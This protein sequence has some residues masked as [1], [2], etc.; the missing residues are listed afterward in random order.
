MDER[1]LSATPERRF[2]RWIAR[3]RG[4]I[5]LSVSVVGF[6]AT[7]TATALELLP[8]DYGL[9]LLRALFEG[10][11]VGSIADWFAVTALFKKIP[12]PFLSRHTNLLARR[13]AAM[14]DGI[15]DM[16]QTQWLS[17][18]AV[19]EYLSRISCSQMLAER[20][21]CEQGRNQLR[22]WTRRGLHIVINHLDH[23]T[24]VVLLEHVLQ[25][26]LRRWPAPEQITP[27]VLRLMRDRTLE[28]QIYTKLARLAV[29]LQEDAALLQS[30]QHM[31]L[32]HIEA[33]AAESRWMRTKLWLGKQFIE[34]EDDAEK[35]GHLLTQGLSA[36]SG[37]LD[38][39]AKQ[40]HHPMRLALRRQVLLAARRYD[41]SDDPHED[42][43]ERLKTLFL[44]IWVQ[45]DTAEH[46]L[47]H[48]KV[49]LQK[50]VQ[51][52]TRGLLATLD[53]FIYQQVSALLTTSPYRIQL[54]TYINNQLSDMVD[55]NPKFFGDIVRESLSTTKLPTQQLIDQVENKVGQ[56]L[57][58]IRVNG[59]LVGGLV[60]V[61]IAAL[62]IAL[63]A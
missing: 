37:Q 30:I 25:R 40:V 55:R 28:T 45:K 18:Q 15:V 54:D 33:S 13:R 9:I 59:A 26:N 4:A 53:A 11:L 36:L 17:P 52:D 19:R 56:D 8:S 42:V 10:A 39:M 24:V 58:W 47:K 22:A 35:A 60:A 63:G 43:F 62:R 31:I 5:A 14:V 38:D 32:E 3:H 21:L 16:V 23:P 46:L 44:D 50:L 7:E 20:V 57:Q 51:E 41:R 49:G 34:G 29:T 2:R 27:F 6:A 48:A 61:T 12:F 1:P